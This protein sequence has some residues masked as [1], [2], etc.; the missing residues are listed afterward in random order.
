MESKCQQRYYFDRTSYH[1]FHLFTSTVQWY[2]RNAE[3]DKADP[4][5][6]VLSFGPVG[7][8]RVTPVRNEY[9]GDYTCEATNRLGMKEFDIKLNEAH[10]PGPVASAKVNFSLSAHVCRLKMVLTGFDRLGLYIYV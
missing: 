6:E 1:I 7:V 4:N 2:L 10:E 8:L 3:I 5:L 9:Y